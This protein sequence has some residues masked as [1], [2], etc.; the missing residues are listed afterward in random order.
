MESKRST[1]RVSWG[2]QSSN[3]QVIGLAVGIA[4][5][6]LLTVSS[7]SGIA[8]NGE[9]SSGE[10]GNYIVA[11]KDSVDRPGAVAQQQA[12]QHDASIHGVYRH[13]LKGYAATLPDEEVEELRRDPRVA[14]VTVDHKVH[15]LEEEANFETETHEEVELFEATIPTGISR[16]FA[17]T[18]KA[19]DIDGKDDLRADVDVAVID[20]GIDYEHPDLDVVADL[21]GKIHVVLVGFVDSVHKKGSESSRVRTTFAHVPDAPVSKAVFA[22]HGGK[23][24][25]LVNSA[26]LCKIANTATVK[27]KGQN[28]KTHDFNA[29]IATSCA[30][31]RSSKHSVILSPLPRGLQ[32]PRQTTSKE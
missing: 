11:L 16:T 26:N 3:S 9:P 4:M 1:S 14:F 23:Q 29:P 32:R 12:D 31:K 19:L 6:L 22:L 13:A 18:N 30:S 21:R 8:A 28:G 20:T 7:A 27:M 2:Q 17:S 24:G 15:L 5:L 10:V 25:L